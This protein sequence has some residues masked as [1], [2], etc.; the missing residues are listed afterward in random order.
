MSAK[1]KSQKPTVQAPVALQAD[2]R[3][4]IIILLSLAL[5]GLIAFRL[6]QVDIAKMKPLT[7]EDLPQRIVKIIYDKPKKPEK[8]KVEA[9]KKDKKPETP[10]E[11]EEEK[12][13]KKVKAK[14]VAQASVAKRAKKVTEKLRSS[15]MLAMLVGKGPTRSRSRSAVDILGGQTTKQRDLDNLMNK[16]DGVQRAGSASDMETQL[17]SRRVKGDKVSISDMVKDFGTKDKVLKKLGSIKVS[18]PKTVG[19]AANS[20][21]RDDKTIADYVKR[22]MR[23]ITMAYNKALKMK[24]TLQGKVTVRFTIEADGSVSSVEIAETSINDDELLRKIKRVVRNWRFAAIP[25]SEGSITVNFP[26]VFQPR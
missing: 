9:S 26:F 2:R 17:T 10:E 18:R 22:K 19:K 11:K 21:N 15:G 4:F 7:V 16:L 24:P 25:A 6:E 23:V 1:P 13:Q 20:A 14:K 12:K 8:K 3:F 5:H